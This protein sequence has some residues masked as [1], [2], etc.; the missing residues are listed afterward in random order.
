M[1]VAF[2]LGVSGRES[3]HNKMVATSRMKMSVEEKNVMQHIG[4]N[5]IVAGV[6]ATLLLF[7]PMQ[8][9]ILFPLIF[10]VPLPVM[11]VAMRLGWIA[12]LT[13]ILFPMATS[14]I[15]SGSVGMA[16]LIFFLFGF[17]PLLAAWML[18]MG[19]G[20][21]HCASAGFYLA[22]AVL[23]GVIL[24]SWLLGVDLELLLQDHLNGIKEQMVAA[25]QK[26]Q[27]VDRVTLAQLQ[28]VLTNWVN[29]MVLIFPGGVTIG[30]FLMQ[31]GNLGMVRRLLSD[32]VYV[33][34]S[35]ETQDALEN[36]HPPFG[37]IWVLAGAV[38]L[39]WSTTGGL[40][41]LGWNV[42]LLVTIPFFLQGMAVVQT[43]FRLYQVNPFLKGL[44]YG[45]ILF[46]EEL[47]L[48]LVVVGLLDF[49]VDFRNRLYNRFGR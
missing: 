30:W 23:V 10:L 49:W 11:F 31:L 9:V 29:T 2:C 24:G 17:F 48:I 43:S 34:P 33:Q 41:Y 26:N 27:E 22:A 45:A 25:I 37:W 18:Q 28:V 13:A 46:W 16:V 5:P 21:R 39:A 19:F 3:Q 42:G 32:M 20:F 15:L 47:S 8:L 12:G 44:F 36:Y 38:F 7:F 6:I 14:W 40:R 35:D 1:P 4:K